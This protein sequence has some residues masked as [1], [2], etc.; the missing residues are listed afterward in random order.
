MLLRATTWPPWMIPWSYALSEGTFPD[1]E[2][3]VRPGITPD[4]VKKRTPHDFWDGRD[5]I[6][7][8]GLEVLKSKLGG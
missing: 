8:K 7:E 2:E 4:V 3:F 5:V 1:G 6:L